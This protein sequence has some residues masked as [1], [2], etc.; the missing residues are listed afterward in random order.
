MTP[1]EKIDKACDWLKSNLHEGLDS[2]NYPMIKCYNISLEDFID[3]FR[4]AMED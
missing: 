1:I 3:D 2:N 4:K